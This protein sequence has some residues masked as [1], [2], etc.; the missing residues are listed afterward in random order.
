[1]GRKKQC[2]PHRS[3]GIVKHNNSEGLKDHDDATGIEEE[4]GTSGLEE[5][6]FFVEVD[7]SSW[8]SS[9]H[10]DVSE[11]IVTNLTLSEEFFGYVSSE[12]ILR[13]RRYSLRFRLSNV[14][15]YLGRM[16]LGHWPVLS[17]TDI[18]LEFTEK[19]VVEEIESNVVLVVGSFD[20]PDEGVSGLVH[21]ANMKFLTLRPILGV[22]LADSCSTLRVRVEILKRAFDSCNSLYDN[23]RELWRKSLMRVMAWLRPEVITSEVRY[24]CSA[25]FDVDSDSH[26]ETDE[27]ASLQRKRARFDASGFYEA[28][29]PSK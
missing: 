29:K 6:P 19:R 15:E 9:E 13:D 18:Y 11:V 17:S 8:D 12:D 25:P 5:A 21:L 16:K 10:Y 7:R 27:S 14:S 26:M 24:G 1:M 3:V 28:I 2:R 4:S 20:G 23:T 22:T